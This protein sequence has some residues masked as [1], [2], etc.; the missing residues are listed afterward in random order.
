MLDNVGRRANLVGGEE[1]G[2]GGPRLAHEDRL[3][4]VVGTRALG[5]TGPGSA[6]LPVPGVAVPDAP[7]DV[8]EVAAPDGRVVED[9]V[10]VDENLA[11]GVGIR[12][13][14]AYARPHVGAVEVRLGIHSR[15]GGEGRQ[16]VRDVHQ[17]V[18]DALR[19]TDQRTPDCRCTSN[20]ALPR[21]RLYLG[22]KVRFYELLC[23]SSYLLL[24]I[25]QPLPLKALGEHYSPK[26]CATSLSLLCSHD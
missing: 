5:R 11:A 8:L 10:D 19:V 2:D 23:A 4:V 26:T 22:H 20:C 17:V 3:R 14:A 15:E 12:T 25:V 7:E 1:P 6:A 13:I 9:R 16:P 21:A 24:P 18:G